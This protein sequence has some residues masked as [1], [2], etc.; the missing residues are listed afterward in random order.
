MGGEGSMMHSNNSLKTNRDLLAKKKRR[1]VFSGSYAS[2]KM[3]SF[4]KASK[5]QL[6]LFEKS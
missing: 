3:A 1:K 2:V 6:S 4:P 5:K